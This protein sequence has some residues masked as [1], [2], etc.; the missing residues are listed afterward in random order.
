MPIQRLTKWL[1]VSIVAGFTFL[2]AP[3]RS[4][5][6]PEWMPT[7]GVEE[8]ESDS[9]PEP[10][11]EPKPEPEGAAAPRELVPT[12]AA[13][14]DAR[15]VALEAALTDLERPTRLWFRSWVAILSTLA[16]GQAGLAMLED[17]PSERAGNLV[18][19]SLSALSAVV[20]I[21]SAPPGRR[22][23]S[24]YRA[25]P[26]STLDEKRVRVGSGHALLYS[27]SA[28]VGRSRAW[29]S[30]AIGFGAGLAAGLGLHLGY[31]DNLAGAVRAA[32][33]TIL[34]TELRIWTRPTRA[35]GHAERARNNV[36]L[37][38]APLMGKAVQGATVGARF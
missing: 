38:A 33:G 17:V 10:A 5:D 35:L 2:R 15:A 6:L 29:W 7:D 27:E 23:A 19:A 4:Q 25:L 36:D 3:A 32:V 31:E 18:G 26:S 12:E 34:L 20:L 13:I 21:V 28:A 30:H 1:L 22:A 24:S 11:R 9:E 37:F 8:S 16:V 14:L